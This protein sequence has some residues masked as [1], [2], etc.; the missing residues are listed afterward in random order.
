VLDNLVILQMINCLNYVDEYKS[1]VTSGSFPRDEY[2]IETL[3]SDVGRHETA[4]K[5][6]THIHAKIANDKVV[7]KIFDT[8]NVT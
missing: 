6:T 5:A 2:G 8:P 7:E 1:Y 4:T 3:L